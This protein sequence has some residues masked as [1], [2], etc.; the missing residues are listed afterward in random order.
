MGLKQV[1]Y[2]HF[3]LRSS[4]RN[5]DI[6]VKISSECFANVGRPEGVILSV[7]HHPSFVDVYIKQK[8]LAH[9]GKNWGI[10]FTHT[11]CA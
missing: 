5:F 6:S 11:M 4:Y 9:F 2:T 3:L 7:A 1:H 8:Y 10:V